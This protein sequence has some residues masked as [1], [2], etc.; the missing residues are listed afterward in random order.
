MHSVREMLSDG[1]VILSFCQN[2]TSATRI[3][4]TMVGYVRTSREDNF[5]AR[6]VMDIMGSLVRVRR[7]YPGSIELVLSNGSHTDIQ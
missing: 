5:H 7:I 2:L 4:V 6:V 1:A 3:L